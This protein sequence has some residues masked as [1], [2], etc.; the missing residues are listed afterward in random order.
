MLAAAAVHTTGV[1][2][3]QVITNIVGITAILS[4]FG[5]M[6]VRSIRR[7]VR[8]QISDVIGT[9]VTPQLDGIGATLAKHDTRIARLEGFN[10]GQRQ[11]VAAAAVT[12]TPGTS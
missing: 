8:D 12:T 11:T 2:W 10:E 6:I 3:D 1:N 7:S 5:A 4:A 9:T